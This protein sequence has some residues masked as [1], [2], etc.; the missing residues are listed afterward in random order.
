MSG[1]LEHPALSNLP[2][3]VLKNLEKVQDNVQLLA[4]AGRFEPLIS[5]LCEGMSCIGFCENT[6]RASKLGRQ[7][8]LAFVNSD[9]PK[10]ENHRS[11]F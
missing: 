1:N 8:V 7:R 6:C 9:Y 5:H 3:E 11:N 2:E 4:A 10:V